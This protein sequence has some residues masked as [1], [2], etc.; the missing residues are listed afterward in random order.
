MPSLIVSE[1]YMF[2]QRIWQLI[3]LQTRHSVM[4]SSQKNFCW[5][6]KQPT[7][8]DQNTLLKLL[9]MDSYGPICTGNSCNCNLLAVMHLNRCSLFFSK[10]ITEWN[11]YCLTSKKAKFLSWLICTAS[12]GLLGAWDSPASLI[13]VLKNSA[14]DSW[15]TK[16]SARLSQKNF[17]LYWSKYI[18]EPLTT[19]YIKTN[20]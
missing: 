19:L 10:E 11:L 6:M 8:L 2:V 1:D 13:W 3:V 14:M 4:K 7:V 5:K 20:F 17:F 15:E 18:E 12:T 16:I 9:I